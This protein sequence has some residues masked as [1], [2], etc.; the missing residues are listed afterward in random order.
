LTTR[1]KRGRPLA[2][3]AVE[4]DARG[5]DGKEGVHL[6]DAGWGGDVGGR[7]VSWRGSEEGGVFE[8]K[9]DKAAKLW[10]VQYKVS[11]TVGRGCWDSSRAMHRHR[12]AATPR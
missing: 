2:A 4:G 10:V 7:M 11:W 8:F 9:L 1:R 5:D 12:D 3:T 6:D